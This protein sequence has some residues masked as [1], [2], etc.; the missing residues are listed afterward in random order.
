MAKKTKVIDK[1]TKRANGI[2]A[3]LHDD[4]TVEVPLSV[5]N[6]LIKE[7]V[8]NRTDDD[9]CSCGGMCKCKDQEDDIRM[10]VNPIIE[11][12]KG[13]ADGTVLFDKAMMSTGYHEQPLIN[14][15]VLADDTTGDLFVEI[16]D[17]EGICWHA[18]L[19]R[20]CIIGTKKRPYGFFIPKSCAA[21]GFEGMG[22]S[23]ME[24][25]EVAKP[26]IAIPFLEDPESV[27]SGFDDDH[28][29]LF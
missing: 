12:R 16:P 9:A 29:Y 1:L 4:E 20:P 24:L 17:P 26:E 8:A 23:F 18:T 27:G 14:C 10:P 11:Y 3:A 7:A 13:Y 22:K 21:E 25:S 15:N 5:L 6:N 19:D 2:P 28:I